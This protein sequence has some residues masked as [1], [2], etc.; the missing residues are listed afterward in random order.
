MKYPDL[1]RGTRDEEC[2][3]FMIAVEGTVRVLGFQT[4]QS[5]KELRV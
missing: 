5:L 2:K 1:L 3:A 4:V